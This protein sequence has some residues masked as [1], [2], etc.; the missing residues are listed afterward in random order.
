MKNAIIILAS[1]LI[2]SGAAFGQKN[3]IKTAI[4]KIT[5]T[6]KK[7][8]DSLLKTLS[9]RQQI[10]QMMMVAVWSN[11][12]SEHIEETEKLILNYGIGGLCFFQG[13]PL[14]QAYQTNYYQQISAIPMLVSIDA[15]W[16]L[17]MRLKS[18]AKFPYQMTLGATGDEDLIYKTGKAMGLQCKRLGIHINFSPV[19]DINTNPNNPIIGFR[20]F[21]ESPE[22]VSLYAS[23]MSKGLQDA[24]IIACAKHFPGHGDSETDSHKELPTIQASC[25]R[26]D[27]VELV[28][29]KR[30]IDEGVGSVMTGHLAVPALDSTVNTPASLSKPIVTDLLKEKMQFSGLVITDALNM[31]GVSSLYGPGY[32][33]AKAA[34]A[35]NDILLF[36]ENVPLAVNL[37]EKMVRSGQID[38][39]ELSRRVL[40]ILQFKAAAGLI[41][42]KPI[43]TE[44]L[45]AD[46]NIAWGAPIEAITICKDDFGYLPFT[47]NT[48]VKTAWVAIGKSN[49]YPFGNVV[50]SNHN[51]KVYSLHRDSSDGYFNRML[52]SILCRNEQIIISLHDQILWGKNR[53][54]VPDAVVNFSKAALKAKP[55]VMVVFGN[56]YLLQKFHEIP[57][58]IV[59]YEDGEIYQEIAAKIIFGRVA[60][61]G[62]LPVGLPPE[63]KA[64]DGIEYQSYEAEYLYQSPLKHG[65]SHDFS[66]S[67]DSLLHYYRLNRAL[68]GGQVL[69]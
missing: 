45:M 4:P 18:L 28:P 49:D 60:A 8:A 17:N 39:T 16:G 11:K 51:I 24:G 64:G 5:A 21:G 26:L 61:S 22:K 40:K 23:L 25:A 62:H 35:G 6:Q 1:I 66:S 7:W 65:F 63:L 33:E 52:D 9:L 56:P 53:N 54:F 69:V 13:H 19:V 29:F 27:S 48:K 36:P 15:E 37:I 47:P 31:K 32:A 59:A 46:L 10:G 20:S 44:N 38:S 55:G 50:K 57:C 67:L 34:L 2:S 12:G 68:P 58:S 42:Y 30:L 41:S 3:A 14:K 43:R